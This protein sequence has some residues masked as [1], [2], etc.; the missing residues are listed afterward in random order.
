MA[1]SSFTSRLGSF[2]LALYALFVLGCLLALYLPWPDSLAIIPTI[3]EFIPGWFVLL[4]APL[5]IFFIRSRKQFVKLAMISLVSGVVFLDLQLPLSFATDNSGPQLRIATYNVGNGP[6]HPDD[7]LDWYYRNEIDAL[8]VQE[9]QAFEPGPYLPDDMHYVCG[10]RLCVISHHPVDKMESLSRQAFKGGWGNYIA[11][12][13]L[14]WNGASIAIY[15]V[16]LN[17][18]RHELEFLR[19]LLPGVKKASRLYVL[20]KL[21]SQ[22]ASAMVAQHPQRRR[23]TIIAGDFNLTPKGAIYREYWSDYS[24]AFSVAGIGTGYTKKTRLLGARIDHILYDDSIRVAQVSVGDS[25]G[26]DHRPVMADLVLQ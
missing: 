26:G 23:Y 16:H 5:V 13:D 25:L 7:L 21:E 12:F 19:G 11:R 22:I 2:G 10:G 24:N 8:L 20:R 14:Q 4:P 15:N 9:T 3:T 17:T 18:P 1:T 6:V